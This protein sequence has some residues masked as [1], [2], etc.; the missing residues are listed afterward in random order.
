MKPRDTLVLTAA[1]TARLLDLDAC[2]TAVE[3]AFRLHALGE[4]LA[5]AVAAVHAP[6]GGVHA[7]V[8]GLRIQGRQYVA[9]KTNANFPGN[10][11]RLGLPT[12][13][14]VVTLF[15]A[16]SG[17][18][19]AILDSTVIT[20]RRTGAATAVAA[21]YLARP[22]ASVATVFGAGEQGD[23]QT[24]ALARV[25]PL[26]QVHL[27]DPA[28]GRAEALAS[29]LTRDLGLRVTPCND[30]I[31]ALAGSHVCVTCTT[32]TRVIVR[33]G[34]VAAGAFVAG[35]GADNPQKHELDPA[36][37]AHHTVVVDLLESC[38][39]IGD[40]HHALDAGVMTSDDVHAEL[41]EIVAG[42]KAGR[43]RADEIIVFDSTGTALQDVAAAVVVY[44]RAQSQNAGQ[45]VPLGA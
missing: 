7:K 20:S 45:R 42:Q 22:D 14:G 16:D 39:A 44:E 34:E 38:A 23:I 31:R 3:E 17:E 15:D 2:I 43:R 36:L 29:R 1:E 18:A 19:L 24:R 5:P 41:G 40:L 9:S 30:P 33:D 10:P 35:V 27:V 28:P 13:Q 32:S 12:I 8:A 11:D 21:R 37:L 25:L 26:T 4:S 6:L